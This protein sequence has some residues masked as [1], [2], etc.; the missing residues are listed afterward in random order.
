[1]LDFRK[2]E[3]LIFQSKVEPL[4]TQ[5]VYVFPQT[6][7]TFL[8]IQSASS[9]QGKCLRQS[10]QGGPLISVFF[11]SSQINLC[12]ST[13]QTKIVYNGHEKQHNNIGK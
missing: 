9:S 10:A 4:H 1:M 8:I 12:L 5:P 13:K 2:K 7:S 6:T 11:T 3:K